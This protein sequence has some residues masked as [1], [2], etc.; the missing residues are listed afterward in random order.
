[1]KIAIL[2]A[3]KIASKMAKTIHCMKNVGENVELYA[4]GS[5]SLEK[6]QA[7]AQREGVLKAYGSYEDMLR[8]DDIDLVYVAT[9]HSH[10]AM[11]MRMCIEH[12]RAVLCEKAFT[13][14]AAQA[15]E[16]LS[17]AH[18]KKVPVAEAIWTR[19]LPSRKMMEERAASGVIGQVRAVTGTLGYA[20]DWKERII[21]P[22]LAGGALLDMG[23]Y[24]INL[25]CMV[26]GGDVEEVSGMALIG[27][28]G[29]DLQDSINIRWKNGNL[30]F[31]GTT[32]CATTDQ[33]AYISGTEG[34]IAVEQLNNPT[35]INVYRKG[36]IVETVPVPEQMTGFEYEVRA[37]MKMLEEGRLECPEMPHEETIRIMRIMDEL[38]HQFG[39]VYPWEKEC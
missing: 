26:L 36:E 35:C 15:E 8:D 32:A 24:L 11:H 38:R 10:H 5:R 25:A 2:G 17:L 7:F 13:T 4:I 19:Y 28:T 6:A 9:P 34:Y 33:T 12:R 37:C 30:A 14:N 29:V 16:I 31:L 22:E 23:V 27:P 3:G 18:Q 20:G 1:M 21:R 39:L